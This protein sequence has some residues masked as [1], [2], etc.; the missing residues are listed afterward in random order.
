MQMAGV[1]GLKQGFAR[2]E[3]MRLTDKFIEAARSHAIRERAPI[4]LRP[5]RERLLRGAA[6]GHA[7]TAAGSALWR[8]DHIDT[9]RRLKAQR[10]CI[11][12]F[13]TRAVRKI[14]LHRLP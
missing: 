3:Q 10:L 6:P 1:D 12:V 14:Q 9:G 13:V 4:A 5:E 7:H 11:D 2:R 8:T